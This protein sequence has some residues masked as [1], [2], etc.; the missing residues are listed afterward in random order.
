MQTDFPCAQPVCPLWG[1]GS[2]AWSHNCPHPSTEKHRTGSGFLVLRLRREPEADKS[3]RLT[4]RS[5][6]TGRVQ[7]PRVGSERLSGDLCL[8]RPLI[9]TGATDLGSG[10]LR[11]ISC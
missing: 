7:K 10:V 11:L 5:S 4:H 3:S 2:G 9:V 6:Q 1:G 8:E